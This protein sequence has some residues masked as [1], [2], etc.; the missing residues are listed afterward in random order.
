M[1]ISCIVDD[2]ANFKVVCGNAYVITGIYDGIERAFYAWNIA[3][4]AD[5]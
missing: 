5:S 1:F 3:E 2:L 4:K